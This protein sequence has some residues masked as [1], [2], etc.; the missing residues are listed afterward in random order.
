MK[1]RPR[2]VVAELVAV[3]RGAGARP[4]FEAGPVIA[5]AKH[6]RKG[7]TIGDLA[8]VRLRGAGGEVIER[9]GRADEIRDVLAALLVHGQL[10]RRFRPDVIEEAERAAPRATTTD[11]GRVDLTGQRVITI[12]PEGAKDHDDAVAVSQ[13]GDAIRLWV[14]IADVAWFVPTGGAIDR[15]AAH[16]ATSVYLPGTV[17][18]MLPERLSTDLCSLRPGDPRKV[19]TAEMLIGPNGV[20]RET[21]FYRSLVRSERRLSYPQVD[22]LFAGTSLGDSGLEADLA[23]ARRVA[24]WLREARMGRGALEIVSGEAAFRFDGDRLVEAVMEGQTPS[25]SLVE[26]CM[27]AANEAVA[28][29]LIGAERQTVFRIHPDPKPRAIERLYDRLEA[30]DVPLPPLSDGPLTP[31]QCSAAARDAAAAVARRLSGGGPGARAFP[32]IVLR[33]LERAYYDVGPPGHS[34]L[35][36]TAYLHFT[37]P[38][39]RYPDLLVHRTL[40][41]ALGIEESAPGLVALA[42]SAADSSEREREA[43]SLENRADRICLAFLLK[44]R[45]VRDGWN[46]AFTAEITGLVPAGAFLAFGEAFEG[47]LPASRVGA[48]DWRLDPAEVMLVGERSGR[49][50]R[51]GETVEVRV[52]SIEPLRGR[53]TVEPV[54]GAVSAA[55][56]P[57]RSRQARRHPPRI[58]RRGR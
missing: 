7:A 12:D 49:R 2:A 51:L 38:I 57:P 4:A 37:S 20:V 11:P 58:N 39:R 8:L 19:V 29:F 27:I 6:S 28:R 30:L 17:V 33:G 48:E 10:P 3:G 53:V 36:S 40:L 41:A 22:A 45:L 18:P 1:D 46:E 9:L 24:E 47:F 55:T 23:C 42:G 5:L 54:E 32:A 13:E 43:Q 26:E 34:G 25:H 14:H 56:G 15:E 50:L 31:D 44:D 16:R 21:R 35:A 52:T